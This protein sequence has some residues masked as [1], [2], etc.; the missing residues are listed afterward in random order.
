[1]KRF[2]SGLI[3]L[4][5][6]I[7]FLVSCSG[8]KPEEKVSGMPA[9]E[10]VIAGP[11]SP[12]SLPALWMQESGSLWNGSEIRVELYPSMEAMISLA[13]SDEVDFMLLPSNTA[14]VLY[15]KGFDMLMMNIFQWGGLNLSSTDPDCGSWKDLEGKTL[16]VPAKGSVPDLTTQLFLQHKGLAA[17]KNIEIVYSN[18]NEIAQL[19]S[20]GS[21]SYA[22]DVQPFVTAHRSGLANYHVI[23]DYSTLWP[24]IAGEGYRMPGFC[25]V[26]KNSVFNGKSEDL[27][28]MNRLFEKGL[29]AIL[30]DPDMAGE[31][32][33]KHMNADS[34]L[35]KEAI[36]DFGMRYVPI[37]ESR[38]DIECYFRFLEE[39]KPAV[40]GGG[41]PGRKLYHVRGE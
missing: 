34:G 39:M 20:S 17:G 26:S 4:L 13:Q 2:Y 10:I 19:L 25:M 21:I 3:I 24:K 5:S 41:L 9:E 33:S 6:G 23:C 40:I 14:A 18:H 32:A 16:Y 38:K 1:M 35:I 15:N 12:A 22:V 11:R 31:L 28:R 37:D 27:D 7:V 30:N 8:K 29:N 36:R